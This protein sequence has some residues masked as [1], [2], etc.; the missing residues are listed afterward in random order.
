LTG[1]DV[2]G[3]TERA[4]NTAALVQSLAQARGVPAEAVALAWLLKHP[5]RIVPVLGTT[6]PDRLA[7]CARAL[8][9]NLTREEW[10]A[11][12]AAARGQAMP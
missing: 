11:L 12:F 3:L 4:H 2:S 5:A 6:R 9:V 8:D 1:G 7:A 10:Y